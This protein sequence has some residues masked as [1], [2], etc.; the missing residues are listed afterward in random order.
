MENKKY[1]VIIIDGIINNQPRV[2][3]TLEALAKLSI[4]PIVFS[5]TKAFEGAICFDL[6]MIDRSPQ[7]LDKPVIIRKLYSLIYRLKLQKTSIQ[8]EYFHT[9]S[10][11]YANYILNKLEP[12][13]KDVVV[14]IA[15]HLINLPIGKFVSEEIDS[16]LIFN[17]HEYYPEQVVEYEGWE[18]RRDTLVRIGNK[19]IK[20]CYK[21]FNVTPGIQ[22]RYE[23]EF[24]LEESQQVTIVNA[25]PYKDLT[26]SKVGEKI[27]LIHHG[28]ANRNRQLELMIEVASKLP[29]DKFEFN[30][31]LVPSPADQEYY[32]FLKQEIDKHSNCNLLDPVPTEQISERIN[33]FD[34]GFYMY[35]N[36]DNFN[37]QHYLP[38][39]LFEFIQAR[40]GV[41]IG[42]YIEMKN[43]VLENEIGIV[44]ESNDPAAMAN[45][46]K[47][48]SRDDAFRFKKNA[49]KAAVELK[50]E[51]EIAKM[52]NVFK[53]ILSTKKTKEYAV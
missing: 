21:V 16:K 38:N 32:D 26:P 10:K 20:D 27:R 22:K 30:F 37:M 47:V 18:K 42:P 2:L 35:Y 50:G 4:V 33:E 25:V 41:V 52:V 49:E 14:V 31:M 13:A 1:A 43:I 46:L 24:G 5:D 36:E 7:H 17:A 44:V 8:N 12:Y 51:N 6:P 39:K 19:F 48:V 53:D 40:L 28:I 29:D 15:H 3:K 11:R 23:Q 34:L 45:E 9:D